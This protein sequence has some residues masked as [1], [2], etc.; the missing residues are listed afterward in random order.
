MLSLVKGLSDRIHSTAFRYMLCLSW[1]FPHQ[2]D[3][4]HQFFPVWRTVNSQPCDA[5]GFPLNIPLE[6]RLAPLVGMSKSL[7]TG[8]LT[9]QKDSYLRSKQCGMY[10]VLR[11]LAKPYK[12]TPASLNLVWNDYY[13]GNWF[14][15]LCCKFISFHLFSQT[16]RTSGEE[17]TCTNNT[18]HL[19]DG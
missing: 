6:L 8:P 7:L 18:W 5:F 1:C 11:K 13:L 19:Y 15:R 10:S 12:F 16:C 17:S 4:S 2:L 3:I 9:S 14:A